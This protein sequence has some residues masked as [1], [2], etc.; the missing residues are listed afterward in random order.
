[1]P[2]EDVSIDADVVEVTLPTINLNI[3]IRLRDFGITMTSK[4]GPISK[5][6][7]DNPIDKTYIDDPIVMTS[8]IL[9][10]AKTSKVG[11]N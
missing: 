2:S 11:D 5:T 7:T 3:P 6:Y 9:I 8:R 1:M 10:I 4:H